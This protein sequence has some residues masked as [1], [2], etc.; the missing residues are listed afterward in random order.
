MLRRGLIPAIPSVV[1]LG[2]SL[3]TLGGHL[4]WQDSGFYL[5][6]VKELGVL[7][8]PGF[9]LY[10]L[11][12]R[13]WTIALG[14][15]DFTI[16]V[17]LFSAV[18]A[19]AAASVLALAG[20]DLLRTKGPVF[21]TVELDGIQADWA[22][23]AVGCLA[24]GGFSFWSAAI[25]AKGYALYFLI[26][27]LLIWRIIRADE[28]RVGRDFTIVAAL[29][30][31]AWQAHPSATLLGPALVLFTVV[32]RRSLGIAGISSRVPLAALCALGPSLLLPLIA[33]RDPALMFGNPRWGSLAGY[34]SGDRFIHP[35]GTFGLEA[36]RLASVGRYFWEE[37]LA[38][39]TVC[40][41]LG[42]YRVWSCHRHLLLGAAAWTAPV[43]IVTVLFKVEGQ[44]DLW[45]VTAWIPIWLLAAVGVSVLLLQY[46]KAAVAVLAA[47]LAWSVAANRADLQQRDYTLAE[48]LG[49]L[50]LDI[51]DPNAILVLYS[52]D[53]LGSALYLQRIKGVRPDVV[54]VQGPFLG[55]PSQWYDT[56]LRRRYPTLNTPEYGELRVRFPALELKSIALGAF[57]NANASQEHPLFFEHPPPPEVLRPGWTLVPAGH[58][59]KMVPRGTIPDRRYW[60]FPMEPESLPPLYRRERGQFI[61]FLPGSVKVRPEAYERRLL[62]ELL[63]ARKNQAD[64]I[65]LSGT[66]EGT[67]RSAELYESILKLDPWMAE[68]RGVVIPL[69]RAYFSLHQF[70]RAEPLLR[71]AHELALPRRTRRQLCLQLSEIYQSWN[72]LEDARTWA[73]AAL[74]IPD[75]PA[76]PQ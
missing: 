51:V 70:D 72:R 28:S 58:L 69:A 62:R 27:S 24:A 1:S 60:S 54:V 15:L 52:D 18:C 42:L 55:D 29:I 11:L 10:L 34:L 67:K 32:H 63:R 64:W 3:S 41:A 57:G 22:G 12:C 35:P 13:T 14:F 48:S 49:H 33:S 43:L 53:A 50:S 6:G 71:R 16:A 76:D 44:S 36:S 65:A 8:P 2:L 61:E 66:P 47:G 23:A 17:H 45:M 37:F 31:L 68:D 4:Y 74:A 73:A 46:R 38:I 5:V 39:G 40:A 19:A 56:V 30:G 21:R 26:S 20:R 25:L 59:L 9:V 75:L 7:Y